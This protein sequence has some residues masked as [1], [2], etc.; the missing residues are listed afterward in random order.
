M[1]KTSVIILSV[2]L[3]LCIALFAACNGGPGDYYFPNFSMGADGENYQYESIV[4]QPF[5][6]TDDETKSY[7]SLDRNTASYSLMRRQIE[8]GMKLSAGSVRLEEYV[9]YFTYNYA[10]PT[11]DNALALGGSVFDCP[12]NTNHKLL[13]VSVAA[14]ELK[15]DSTQGNNIV[16]LIDTSGSMYG[17][18]RL[19]LIQ[20]AFTMLLESLGKGDVISV[21]TYAGDSRVALDGEPATNKVKIA[22]VIEDL[23]ARGSTNGAGGLQNAYKIAEKH[24]IP[25]GNNRVI[26]ATDGDFN[27]GVS[28]KLGLEK[29]ISQ[30]RESGVY[31]SVLGVG[32][33]NTNDTTMETLARNGN[34]NYAYLDSI[35]EA[36]KVLVNELNG[37]L[38]TVA[39]DAK[40]GVE[41]NPGVVSKYRLLGY[42]T[43]LL[44]EEQFEDDETDA[45]EIGSGHTVTAVYEIELKS[46]R[47]GEIVQGEIATAEVKYKKP[48]MSNDGIEQNKS[49][50]ITF[51]TSD[52]TETPSDDC[53]FIGCVLEYGLILRQS[54][55]KGDASFTAVLSRLEQLTV[56]LTQDDFKLDFYR[57]VEKA[58]VLYNYHAD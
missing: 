34:G 31:L 54:K 21:V 3:A 8:S 15:F 11:G 45:G 41:F 4:E 44:T 50:S 18:D 30:K 51:K 6:S 12:W 32:M 35:L 43:K 40:I 46:N 38:V 57:L 26:L 47:D 29:L 56:Y 14:E 19:G 23:Q 16:F 2:L 33:L 28:S 5:V 36:K 20:Q 39:K 10:R 17:A 22:S 1:K 13:S 27:V 52:Y 24:F 42:D 49:V 53:V 48:A 37:T 9:N 7:F 58:N 55:Y 25:N